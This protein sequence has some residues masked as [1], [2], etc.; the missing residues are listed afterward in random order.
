M[1]SFLL[2]PLTPPPLF[3]LPS[4][5]PRGQTAKNAQTEM[6]T[7]TQFSVPCWQKSIYVNTDYHNF[8][9]IQH[10][11]CSKPQT[12]TFGRNRG[13]QDFLRYFV[14]LILSYFA[15]AFVGKPSGPRPS[16][17]LIPLS[18]N[19]YFVLSVGLCRLKCIISVVEI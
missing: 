6:L 14:S 13:A 7:S 2:S 11:N 1:V 16:S 17:I 5:F 9:F 18:A 4:Q 12:G 10:L 3:S 19:S 15:V 8:R